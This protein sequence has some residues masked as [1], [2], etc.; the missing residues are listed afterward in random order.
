MP[1]RMAGRVLLAA[2]RLGLVD[3]P[4]HDRAVVKP[5]AQPCAQ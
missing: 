1:M 3:A 5:P 4:P 2:V